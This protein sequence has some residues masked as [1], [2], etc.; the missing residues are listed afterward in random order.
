MGFGAFRLSRATVR[1]RERGCTPRERHH[2]AFITLAI[3]SLP[4]PV[5]SALLFLILIALLFG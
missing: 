2:M 3:L 5:I 4:M 1:G